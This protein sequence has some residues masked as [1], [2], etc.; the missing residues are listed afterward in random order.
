MVGD[1]AARLTTV[2]DI[3]LQQWVSDKMAALQATEART[4]VCTITLL[5]E[6]KHAS[7]A[8]LEV[9]ATVV[10]LQL[11]MNTVSSSALPPPPSEGDATVV[12]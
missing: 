5:L 4:R 12:A 6:E 2:E 10:A 8:A 3:V 11:A 1:D 9:E 7:V